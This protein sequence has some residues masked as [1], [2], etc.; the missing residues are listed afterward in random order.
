MKTR[1]PAMVVG[2]AA[3]L[4]AWAVLLWLALWPGFYQGVSVS[5]TLGESSGEATRISA[6][7]IEANGLRVLPLLSLPVLLTG[8]GLLAITAQRRWSLRAGLAV[9]ASA[10]LLLLFSAVAI[11]SIGIFYLPAAVAL[12]AAA[13]LGGRKKP[14]PE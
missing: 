1:D 14:A 3:H 6:S 13:V 8:V 7:L 9:W 11:W 5:T 4:L 12:L 2:W 10:I